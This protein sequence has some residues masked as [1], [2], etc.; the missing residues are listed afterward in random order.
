MGIYL[1]FEIASGVAHDAARVLLL[2]PVSVVPRDE[3]FH[4]GHATH[5]CPFK[6]AVRVA[7]WRPNAV[8]G[9]GHGRL[10]RNAHVLTPVLQVCPHG[11]GKLTLLDESTIRTMHLI[12]RHPAVLS[13]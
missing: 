11:L 8:E 6:G 3:G 9:G 10:K 13:D 2:H 7:R 4:I 12:A 1:T 5:A